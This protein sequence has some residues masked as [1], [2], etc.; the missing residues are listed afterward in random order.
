MII[1]LAKSS[2]DV[3]PERKSDAPEAMHCMCAFQGLQA[4]ARSSKG[5]VQAATAS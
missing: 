3:S 5:R 1:L 4:C 2:T